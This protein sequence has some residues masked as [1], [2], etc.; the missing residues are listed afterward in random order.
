M[1]NYGR[2][3]RNEAENSWL[4]D[5]YGRLWTIGSALQNR[6]LQVRFLSHLPLLVLEMKRL[7]VDRLKCRFVVS[8][9]D[10]AKCDANLSV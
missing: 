3:G 5:D 10:D 7:S 4:K 1:D 8:R 2:I 6:R 9:A